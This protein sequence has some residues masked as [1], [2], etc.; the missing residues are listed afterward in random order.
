LDGIEVYI[1]A[2]AMPSHLPPLPLKLFFSMKKTG[3]NLIGSPD[4]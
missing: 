4:N 1:D 3:T 2:L